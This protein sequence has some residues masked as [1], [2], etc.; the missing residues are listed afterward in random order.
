MAAQTFLRH[1]PFASAAPFVLRQAT[2]L[3]ALLRWRIMPREP[4]AGLCQFPLHAE[5]V[6]RL[7]G[8]HSRFEFTLVGRPDLEGWFQV[9]VAVDGPEG[10]WRA[11][12]RCLLADE[13]TRLAE[14]LQAAAEAR[15]PSD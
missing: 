12:C 11:A 8:P 2:R 6:V 14:W 5:W 4:A 9:G 10:S 3:M 15:Q 7:H 1:R 13:V